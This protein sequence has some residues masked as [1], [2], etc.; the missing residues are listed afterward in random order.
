MPVQQKSKT[1]E[2]RRYMQNGGWSVVI[3]TQDAELAAHVRDQ[4]E[5]TVGRRAPVDL[6]EVVQ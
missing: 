2:V 4:M 3:R 6:V 5:R 1:Y